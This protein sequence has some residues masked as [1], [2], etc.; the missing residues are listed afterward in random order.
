MVNIT[1]FAHLDNDI[2]TEKNEVFTNL[3]FNQN[4]IILNKMPELEEAEHNKVEVNPTFLQIVDENGIVVFHSANL[5]NDQFLF[6]PNSKQETFYNHEINGQK[7]RIGQFPIKNKLGK[8][9]GQLTIAVS[10]NES[11]VILNNLILVLLI[12]FP[13]MLFI[14]YLAS[15]I[16]ASKAIVPVYKL[17]NTTS[18]I[19]ESNIGT[20]LALPK[21][22]DELYKLTSTINELLARIEKSMLQQK[23]FTSDASH[24]IRTPLSAIRGTLEVLIRKHREPKVYEE[25]INDIITQVD[26]LDILLDQLLQ[27]TRIESGGTFGKKEIIQLGPLMASLNT[28]WSQIASSKKIKLHF[29]IPQDVE[30][31]GDK[32]FLEL[33]LENLVIN[34]IKY[35]KD[36][37]NIFISWDSA[38]K[39]LSVKDD[40]IGIA[41][42]HLPHI[43]NSF[44]RTDESRSSTIK[45]NGL[46]LSIVKKLADFQHILLS[47]TSELG[48]GSN[49]TL[50]F[51]L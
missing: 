4:S 3:D 14:Q 18:G 16:A 35:G 27:I 22:K 33:I 50:Q 6:N 17:I 1:A 12:S 38:L 36:N 8:I 30:I 5:M 10:Q 44:Y 15:S 2:R 28:K 37:G 25:K 49:F 45:G 13:L 9:I 31:L 34:A 51:T 40:G 11:F 42:G 24:E 26:R 43:F 21:R 41:A 29:Q 7:I 39:T 20:R 32:F 47:V 19:S 46:G 23:Q 48:I